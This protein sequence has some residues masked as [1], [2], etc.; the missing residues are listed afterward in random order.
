VIVHVLSNYTFVRWVFSKGSVSSFQP[1]SQPVVPYLQ[2]FEHISSKRAYSEWT[3]LHADNLT[4][5]YALL[6]SASKMNGNFKYVILFLYE[7]R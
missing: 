1:H 7:P 6:R 5:A 4:V 3:L 2:A